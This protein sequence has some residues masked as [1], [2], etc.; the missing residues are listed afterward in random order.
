MVLNLGA[1]QNYLR[2]LFN[3]NVSTHMHSYCKKCVWTG[4]DCWKHAFC[5]STSGNSDIFLRGHSLKKG[6]T[7]A[8]FFH[9]GCGSSA[10]GCFVCVCVCVCVALVE[11]SVR[12]LLGLCHWEPVSLGKHCF[13]YV[14]VRP[15]Y[16]SLVLS[17]FIESTHCV[18]AVVHACPDESE[19]GSPWCVCVALGTSL[20]APLLGHSHCLHVTES[21]CW[22]E[23]MTQMERS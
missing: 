12:V 14:F 9:A 18:H 4:R 7:I 23:L 8:Y 15:L 21:A 10:W 2:E 6:I 11:M 17:A 5:Q 13:V 1:Y 3:I 20:W 19:C 16:V 22:R